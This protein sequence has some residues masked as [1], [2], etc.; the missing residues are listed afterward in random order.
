PFNLSSLEDSLNSKTNPARRNHSTHGGPRSD[1]SRQRVQPAPPRTGFSRAARTAA[2]TSA[3]RVRAHQSGGFARPFSRAR[4]AKILSGVARCEEGSGC[5][6]ATLSERNGAIVG[7]GREDRD[8]SLLAAARV[9][10]EVFWRGRDR[11]AQGSPVGF[12]LAARLSC[13]HQFVP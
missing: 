5:P 3:G 11:W 6:T 10:G 9:W 12:S 7:A 4:E 1:P 8:Q 2:G 13:G